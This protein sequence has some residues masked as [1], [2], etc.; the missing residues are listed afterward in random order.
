MD[1]E[2]PDPLYNPPQQQHIIKSQ[3]II[4]PPCPKLIMGKE[5]KH[6]DGGKD[7]DRKTFWLFNTSSEIKTFHISDAPIGD[8]HLEHQIPIYPN[9]HQSSPNTP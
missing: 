6:R 7:K 3:G 9:S 1:R 4:V 5:Y 8:D 2:L